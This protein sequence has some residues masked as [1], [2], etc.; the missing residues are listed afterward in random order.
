M[1]EEYLA[2]Y[3]QLAQQHA[4]GRRAKAPA[5]KLAGVG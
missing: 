3:R 2:L 5:A 1:A 4:H